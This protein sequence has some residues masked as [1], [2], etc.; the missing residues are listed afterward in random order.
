MSGAGAPRH[1]PIFH[2]FGN[3]LLMAVATQ[4]AASVALPRPPG[5]AA[6]TVRAFRC[7]LVGYRRTWRGSVWS[8]VLGPLFYLGAM[9]YGLG[10][11]VD[12]KGTAALGGVPYV[13]F[14]APAVLC[15]QAMNTALSNT[16]YPVFAATRWNAVYLAARATTLR[17]KDIFRG[18]LLFIGVRIAMNSAC[19]IV[20]VAAFGLV[21]SA[22]AVLLLPVAL[23]TGLAFAAPVAAWVVTRKHE[24][25]LNYPIRFGAVPLMLFSGTFFP[26]SQLPGWIRPVAYATP[27]WHGVALC[28]AL[29]VGDLNPGSVAINVGYLAAL[30]A[31][32]V[33]LSGRMY[34]RRLYV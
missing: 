15:V 16:L 14:V 28:R 34:R 29:S 10:S 4:P 25:S 9:G 11:L 33:W 23:L 18:H 3:V 2:D 13:V 22:W 6:L 21:K 20:F 8:S 24:T 12:A 19:Y 30:T 5:A 1:H 7:Y 27:L 26:I 32:G 31:I 17:P